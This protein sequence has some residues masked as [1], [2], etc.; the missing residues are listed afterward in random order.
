MYIPKAIKVYIHNQKYIINTVGMTNSKVLIFDD[1]VLK[2]EKE[3]IESNN[4]KDVLEFLQG[5]VKVPKIIA[6]IKENGINYLLM[7]KL[8]GYMAYEDELLK[9]P[10]NAIRLLASALKKLWSIDISSYKSDYN[11]DKKLDYLDYRVNNQLVD[12]SQ[13]DSEIIG[14]LNTPRKI[15]AFLKKH[16]PNEDN[17]FTHGDYCLPNVFFKENTLVGFIDLGRAAVSDRYQDISLCIRSLRY[18]LGEQFKEAYI[19]LFL[20]ELDI[21]FDK[22]KYH[23]Y[24]LLDELA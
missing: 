10:R 24:L 23:Y 14:E 6:H 2:I 15:I 21:K 17:V 20:N 7:T 4:E 13:L 18:N 22:E 5:K 9:D 1:Y 8:D 12:E 11:L 19:P 16:K 3:T